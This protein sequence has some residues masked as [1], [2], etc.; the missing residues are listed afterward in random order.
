MFPFKSCLRRLFLFP[1]HLPRMRVCVLSRGMYT[2]EGAAEL[3]LFARGMKE[4]RCG[5]LYVWCHT[6]KSAQPGRAFAAKQQ[7]KHGYKLRMPRQLSALLT[8]PPLSLSL[9][10]S[11]RL[12]SRQ[13]KK[14]PGGGSERERLQELISRGQAFEWVAASAGLHPPSLLPVWTHLD[15]PSKCVPKH[16]YKSQKVA[17]TLKTTI[18]YVCFH[19]CS[20]EITW[21]QQRRLVGDSPCKSMWFSSSPQRRKPTWG[22]TISAQSAVLAT[23]RDRSATCMLICIIT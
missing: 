23:E 16:D 20:W 1:P 21:S 2:V 12:C 10:L 13:S 4:R 9:S 3:N 8:F 19:C 15:H 17:A 5:F 11:L 22:L 7:H 14:L 18:D 6:T